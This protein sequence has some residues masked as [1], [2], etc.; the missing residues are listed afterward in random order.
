MVAP[1]S[2]IAC[3]KSPARSGGVIDTALVLISGLAAGS[4]VSMWNN[5]A[6]TRSIFPST[7]VA[8]CPKAMAATAAKTLMCP[9]TEPI[10]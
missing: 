10:R 2:I 5:R 4:G 3:A 8:F 6:V 1:K 7:G 9:K